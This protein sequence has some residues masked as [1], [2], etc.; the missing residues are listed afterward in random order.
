MTQEEQFLWDNYINMFAPNMPTIPEHNTNRQGFSHLVKK[1][2]YFVLNPYFY[3]HYFADGLE[4]VPLM[5]PDTGNLPKEFVGFNEMRQ[6]HKI[7][8]TSAVHFYIADSYNLRFYDSPEKYIGDLS[9]YQCVIGMDISIFNDIPRA[10]N[11]ANIAK[12]RYVGCKLQELGYRVI[13]SVSWGNIDSLAYCLL[14]IPNNSNIAIN[15][16]TIG[17]SKEERFITRL[18]IEKLVKEKTPKHLLVYGYPLSFD[19]GVPVTYYKS[20]IQ[21]LREYDKR[22]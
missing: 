19:P 13:P 6:P 10:L 7:S 22:K 15:H 16:S 8:S 20:R 14:G 12:C 5:R 18:A 11:V 9:P 4:G 2:H 21:K 1:E 3:G 17:R